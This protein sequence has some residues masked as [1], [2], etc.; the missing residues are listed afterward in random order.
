MKVFL[1]Q[2][3]LAKPDTEDPERPL[4]EA[5]RNDINRI[6]SFISKIPDIHVS[7]IFHSGKTRAWQ[8]SEILAGHLQLSSEV[9]QSDG[10]K[11]KDD[12]D[13]W[14]QRLS[15][16]D[17]DIMLVGHMPYMCRL[18]SLL[19]SGGRD[20]GIVDFYPGSVVCL[21]RND[22]GEWSICWMV[23]PLMI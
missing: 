14:A 23:S 11:P 21:N 1:V 17:E 16:K 9:L 12:P 4:S 10:L 2:H 19:T 22:S 3:A 15:G 7:S 20:S 5:G 8:T 6:A 13:I 18:A